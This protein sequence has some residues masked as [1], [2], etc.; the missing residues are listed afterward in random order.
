MENIYLGDGLKFTSRTYS[1]FVAGEPQAEYK[2]G[3]ELTEILD[4]TVEEEQAWLAKL[5]V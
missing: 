2:D 5:Q 3:P 4:P 1:P